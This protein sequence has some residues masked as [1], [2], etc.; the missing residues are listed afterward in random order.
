M[1][2]NFDGDGFDQREQIRDAVDIVD[3]VERYVPLR[4]QG[5]NFVGRCPWHDDSRPSLQVNA[6]RQ[7]FKC[8]V[9]NIGGDVFSFVMKIE[10]VDFKESMQILADIAGIELKRANRRRR[11]DSTGVTPRLAPPDGDPNVALAEAD[12]VATMEGGEASEALPEIS[13]PAIYRAMEWLARKYRDELLHSSEAEEARR[14]VDERGITPSTAEAFQIGY[15]PLSPNALLSWVGYDRNR[16]RVLEASGT[17]AYREEFDERGRARPRPV[18]SGAQ[19]ALEERDRYYDRFRGRLIFPI[20]DVQDR[21]V[22]FGGRLLPNTTL[23]S[24]AKYV[25]SPET[26]IFTKSKTLYGLDRARNSIRKSGTVLIT[27][28]YTD[29][30]VTAQFG[31]ENVVAALGTA[32]GAEH[33]RILKRFADKMILMLDGDEAGQ[34]RAKEVLRFFVEQGVDMSVLTLPDNEDPCEFLLDKGPDAF[35]EALATQT[36]DALDHAFATAIAG[37]DLE[38]DVV[39]SAK[40]LDSL[41][42]TLAL[43]PAE[44]RSSR[45]PSRLRMIGAVQ[46]YATRF[47]V[48]EDELWRQIA[49]KR[50]RA[51]SYASRNRDR[52]ERYERRAQEEREGAQG[53]PVDPEAARVA[54]YRSRWVY[55][56][57]GPN[58]ETDEQLRSLFPPFEAEVWSNQRLMPSLLECE[59]LE[60]WLTA[61]ELFG[62]LVAHIPNE[63]LRS[64]V[65]VQLDLLA[66]DMLEQGVEPTFDRIMLRYEDS[67]MK[68][69]LIELDANASDKDLANALADEEKRESI[70]HDVFLGFERAKTLREEPRQISLLREKET[71]PEEKL[72]TLLEL[73]RQQR[74]KQQNRIGGTGFNEDA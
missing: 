33:V 63:A 18:Y 31:F 70:L 56:V 16:A 25:N 65:A 26:Q 24:Q 22:A 5:A 74:E 11:I 55:P 51:L 57:S 62:R 34:K 61:P 59:Y 52:D 73:Q 41:L 27:E 12:Y 40:A 49:E 54:E 36:V 39:G 17:L 30:I 71:S 67:A 72:K 32:L 23:K 35:R 43:Y 48:T 37:V 42:E 38:N 47:R 7:T 29:C 64:P 8:W 10:N 45:D 2:K 14:Y 13:K 1:A 53:N 21:V 60:I 15:S 69:F 9:C 3:L 20:R 28:G 68:S 6:T 44:S 4:R 58:E 66:R 50:D 19:L 46:R